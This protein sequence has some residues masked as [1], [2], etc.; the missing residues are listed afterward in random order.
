MILPNNTVRVRLSHL[1]ALTA[2]TALG[3][4]APHLLP[5]ADGVLART[6]AAGPAGHDVIFRGLPHGQSAAV[7]AESPE[8]P[9]ITDC[10]A[11]F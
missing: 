9:V 2:G 8:S 10:G 5:L 6:T 4:V 11:D 7:A 1:G 3:G